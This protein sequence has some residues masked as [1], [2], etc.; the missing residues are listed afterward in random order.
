ANLNCSLP[1]NATPYVERYRRRKRGALYKIGSMYRRWSESARR[2][3]NNVLVKRPLMRL[4]HLLPQ[5]KSAGGEGLSIGDTPENEPLAQLHI[6]PSFAT[7]RLPAIPL[8]VSPAFPPQQTGNSPCHSPAESSVVTSSSADTGVS[9]ASC[10]R[11]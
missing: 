5:L 2:R 11:P 4:R 10:E 9:I 7:N 1:N 3:T 6:V 8:S